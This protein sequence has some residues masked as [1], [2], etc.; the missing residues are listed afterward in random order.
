MF[1]SYKGLHV[2][3]TKK[4]P[5]TELSLKENPSIHDDSKKKHLP[6]DHEKT[7]FFGGLN[8]I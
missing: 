5:D 7:L 2:S 4:I 3:S 6:R 1:G 8:L